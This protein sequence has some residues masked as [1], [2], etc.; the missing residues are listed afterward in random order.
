VIDGRGKPS[1]ASSAC[2]FSAAVRLGEG[3][4]SRP[5][6]RCPPRVAR[7]GQRLASAPLQQASEPRLAV[8]FGIDEIDVALTRQSCRAERSLRT[9][10]APRG[11]LASA[12]PRSRS[13]DGSR[14]LAETHRAEWHALEANDGLPR[15]SITASRAPA[16]PYVAL[17]NNDAVP[18]PGW[19]AALVEALE[20]DPALSFRC[21][22]HAVHGRARCECGG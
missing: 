17:L 11:R 7:R 4:A 14:A 22:A 10:R 3:R 13:V 8:R 9:R 2:H 20:C 15:P 5:R 18:E 6:I 19:L 12:R 16:A 21:L 1:L